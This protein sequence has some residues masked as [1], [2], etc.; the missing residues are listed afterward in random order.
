MAN[1]YPW[2]SLTWDESN[3]K[4]RTGYLRGK[5]IKL[6]MS[7]LNFTTN[8]A[9]WVVRER[10]VV[11]GLPTGKKHFGTWSIKYYCHI[12]N[13]SWWFIKCYW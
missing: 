5:Q 8:Q 3:K 12:V 11:G 7:N 4:L 9:L 6:A 2:I 1:W 13:L 10:Q